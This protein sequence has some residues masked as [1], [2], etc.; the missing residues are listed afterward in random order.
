MEEA[1]KRDHRVIFTQQELVY[2]SERSPGSPFFTFLGMRVYAAMQK[3]IRKM[4][5]KYGFQEVRTTIL[6]LGRG[7][8]AQ[9][10]VAVF[11]LV[12]C[13]ALAWGWLEGCEGGC[14]ASYLRRTDTQHVCARCTMLHA[15]CER[16]GMWP[17]SR[18][19]STCCL[20]K[21]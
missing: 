11:A 19:A 8:C 16:L 1:R 6:A 13:R 12:G 5:K 2:F 15:L 18:D 21:A 17:I 3:L 7:G 20:T 4:Y 14:Y 9:G 10:R